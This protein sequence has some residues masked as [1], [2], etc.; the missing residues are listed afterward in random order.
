[1]IR[2]YY[3]LYGGGAEDLL[4]KLRTR[5]GWMDYLLKAC[6]NPELG[7]F[8]LKLFITIELGE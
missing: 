8:E 2:H 7:L 5:P 3:Q 4:Y 6:N 1:M